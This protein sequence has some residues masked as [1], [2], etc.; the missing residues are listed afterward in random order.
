M[1]DV[2]G[3]T[4]APA[5]EKGQN[6]SNCAAESWQFSKVGRVAS[7]DFT[8]GVLVLIMV[9]YHWLN[10][11]VTG[12]DGIY[13]YLRFLPISF[14]FISGFLIAQVYLS[15]YGKSDLAVAKR[16]F[17]RG[18]KLLAIVAILNLAPRAV[19]TSAFHMRGDSWSISEF[20]EDYFT[21]VHPIAFSVLVPIAYLLIASAGIFI[22]AKRWR[23]VYHVSCLVLV[24]AAIACEVARINSGY[25]QIV[26]I[27][28]IGV[29]IGH[30]PLYRIDSLLGY[31]R[32]IFGAYLA[33]VLAIVFLN[34]SYIL[35]V[36]GVCVTLLGIYWCGSYITARHGGGKTLVLVGQYSLFSYISQIAVLQLLRSSLRAFGTRSGVSI[37]ALL[38]CAGCTILAV[39]ILDSARRREPKINTMYK[40]VF[41]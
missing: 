18:L 26:S 27:G 34:D 40:A 25:V 3:A 31:G 36:I 22:L 6:S 29:S 1:H 35:Q 2:S 9:L 30:M 32:A 38:A 39:R 28:M 5:I 4:M 14:T 10:Y 8:K 23:N 21:G 37:A 12:H 20:A 13:K 24:L 15:E 41:S 19:H 11:F 17:T 33:Y 16:L 7:I